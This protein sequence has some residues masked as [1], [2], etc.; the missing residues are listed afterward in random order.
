M[1]AC[2]PVAPSPEFVELPAATWG[3]PIDCVV[4]FEKPGGTELRS[5]VR[6][7]QPP[8]LS[9]LSRAFWESS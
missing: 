2:S 3:A 6:S 1:V 8:D 7:S 9:A 4:E 5:Q